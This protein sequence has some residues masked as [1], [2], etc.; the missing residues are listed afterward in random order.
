METGQGRRSRSLYPSMIPRN[1]WMAGL[2]PRAVG[3]WIAWVCLGL[4]V[5]QV[6]TNSASASPITLHTRWRT[7]ST[8][9][10]EATPHEGSVAWEA[11]RTAVVVCDMWDQHHCP[12]A[13]ERVGEMAPAMNEVLQAARAQ[14]MLILHCPSDTLK[15]YQDHPGRKLAQAAPPVKTAIPLQGWC[16]RMADHEAP[17]PIDDSDGGCDGCPECPGYG[18]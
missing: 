9:L 8:N 5:A 7:G 6:T 16:S 11:S 18:A 15:F 12:D 14:G 1:P 2:W 4:A 13:T 10:A 17:L 3:L